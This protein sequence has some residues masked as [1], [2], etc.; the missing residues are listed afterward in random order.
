MIPQNI[1]RFI[2]FCIVGASG[3]G[4]N[5]GVFWLLH[6]QF[7]VYDLIANPIAIEISIL[8]NFLFNDIWTWGDRR[9]IGIKALLGRLVRYH[10]VTSAVAALTDMLALWVLTRFFEMNPYIAK[11][12]GIG[13]GTVL[14]FTLNHFWTFRQ[15]KD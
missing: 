9:Q 11:A 8:S 5:F 12:I 7:N 3:V 4:V 14:N 13:L 15:K 2:K 10:V 1:L 6:S